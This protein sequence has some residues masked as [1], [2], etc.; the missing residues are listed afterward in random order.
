VKTTIDSYV[1]AGLEPPMPDAWRPS[2]RFIPT[3]TPASFSAEYL[4]DPVAVEKGL[5]DPGRWV[6]PM[7]LPVDISP[8]EEPKNKAGLLFGGQ[9]SRSGRS[10]QLAKELLTD[11]S[12]WHGAERTIVEGSTCRQCRLIGELKRFLGG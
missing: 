1:E 4:N 8:T 10:D 5:D 2:E 7:P 6:K 11:L 3:S 12:S 9:I